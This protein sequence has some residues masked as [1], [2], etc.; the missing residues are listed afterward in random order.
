MDV[1]K[2]IVAERILFVDYENIQ[3][4]AADLLRKTLRVEVR[5][6]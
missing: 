6:R 2:R 5:L 4:V 1:R 3:A